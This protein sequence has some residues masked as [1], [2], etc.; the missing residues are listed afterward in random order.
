MAFGESPR[1]PHT[2]ASSSWILALWG[3]VEIRTMVRLSKQAWAHQPVLTRGEGRK[4]GLEFTQRTS[5]GSLF[6]FIKMRIKLLNR[7]V[8]D[9]TVR[10]VFP[11]LSPL[12]P[13]GA[14]CDEQASHPVPRVTPSAAQGPLGIPSQR[15]LLP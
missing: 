15:G 11:L 10:A 7:A 2:L 9:Q 4:A 5:P 12:L 1:S 3:S 8:L 14:F 6:I 13:S